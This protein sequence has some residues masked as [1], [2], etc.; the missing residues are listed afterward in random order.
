MSSHAR[1]ICKADINTQKLHW[2]IHNYAHQRPF[3]AF[4]QFYTKFNLKSRHANLHRYNK[5]RQKLLKSWRGSTE[6]HTTRQT[7]SAAAAHDLDTRARRHATSQSCFAA[8]R[9]RRR[10]VAPCSMGRMGL[11]W[12]LAFVN[13]PENQPILSAVALHGTIGFW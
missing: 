1:E 2:N 10:C 7:E 4:T 13:T 12:Y 8:R 6:N 3:P 9:A 11:I 5:K